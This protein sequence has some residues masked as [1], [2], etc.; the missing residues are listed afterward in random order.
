MAEG[1]DGERHADGERRQ[2]SRHVT[3]ARSRA[4]AC[5]LALSSMCSFRADCSERKP[6]S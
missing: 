4:F 1:R 6:L 2:A 3:C 5:L